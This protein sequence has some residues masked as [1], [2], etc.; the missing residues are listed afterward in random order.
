MG[1]VPCDECGHPLFAVR[2]SMVVV[3]VKHHGDWH[4]S[5]VPL[6]RLLAL[7]TQ[8]A[9]DNTLPMADNRLDN[10]AISR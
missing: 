2:G 1:F 10:R 4:T 3:K 5:V 6:A 7:A 8:Q 9:L